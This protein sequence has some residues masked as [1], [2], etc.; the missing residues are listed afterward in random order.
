MTLSANDYLR[1]H[2]R[3]TF[4]FSSFIIIII[5]ITIITFLF[6]LTFSPPNQHSIS[7]LLLGRGE[8]RQ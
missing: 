7:S 2:G 6:V 8:R 3:A 5:T 1:L 4:F